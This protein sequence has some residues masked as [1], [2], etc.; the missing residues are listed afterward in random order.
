M[1][2]VVLLTDHTRFTVAEQVETV[3]E[4]ALVLLVTLLCMFAAGRIVRVVGNSGISV[5]ARVMGLVLASLAVHGGVLAYRGAW[6]RAEG[7]SVSRV[8]RRRGALTPFDPRI[9]RHRL[10]AD[11]AAAILDDLACERIDRRAA[12][13][14]GIA[15]GLSLASLRAVAANAAEA[16][17]TS[18]APIN[19][20][21]ASVD[22]AII[23]A[24]S[25]GCVLAHRLS[26]DRDAKV[27]MIEAGGPATLQQI[28]VP[29]DWPSLSG[30]AVD[31]RYVTT[32]QSGLGGRLVPYPRGKVLGGSSAING[33]AYQHGHRSGYDRWLRE[34]CA[35]WG[36]DDLLPWFKRA[37]TFSGGAD[38]WHGG[39][40]PLHV[41]TLQRA[42]HRHPVAGA[43]IDAATARGFPFSSDIGGARTT[44]AAWNQLE[45]QRHAA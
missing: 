6:I 22:I 31:W 43:F 28:A 30:S 19:A 21:P 39:D 5:I 18:S 2:T 37:E 17:T 3:I 45:H 35:G 20:P 34:G 1:L 10:Q 13:I 15:A 11:A 36:F 12:L 23:G 8:C 7:G 42:P 4:I 26:A 41:L 27:L 29:A 32:P 38:A 40:G 9:F 44:G 14:A 16:A 33:L 24:G 25:A